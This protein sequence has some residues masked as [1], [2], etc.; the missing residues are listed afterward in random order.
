MKKLNKT[1]LHKMK[2]IDVVRRHYPPNST[3]SDDEKKGTVVFFSKY[4][5]FQFDGIENYGRIDAKKVTDDGWRVECCDDS[6]LIY[7]IIRGEGNG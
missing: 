5:C 7:T 4:Y 6:Y 3:V 1:S 2:K